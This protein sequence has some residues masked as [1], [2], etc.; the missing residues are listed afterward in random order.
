MCKSGLSSTEKFK[1]NETLKLDPRGL[2]AAFSRRIPSVSVVKLT[3]K[4]SKLN[5]L[6]KTDLSVFIA[7]LKTSLTVL[8]R[9]NCLREFRH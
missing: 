7:E 3:I 5:R 6:A 8:Q 2:N 9:K 4:M 1:S